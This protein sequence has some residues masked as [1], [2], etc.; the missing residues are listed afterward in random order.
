MKK[1]IISG[2]SGFIGANL[3]RRLLKDGHCVHLIL[4]DEHKTWRLEEIMADIQC[5]RVDIKNQ[6]DVEEAVSSIKPDWIFHL[7]AYGA[8]S[9][10]NDFQE[11]LNTNII[12]T[13][14]LIESAIKSGFES[15]INVGSSSEYGFKD[16]A[17]SERE[18][19]DPNSHYALTKAYATMYCRYMAMNHQL[20]I[21]TLRPYSV[22]GPYEEP[23]RF[24]PHLIVKGLECKL[25]PLV[26]PDVARDYIYVDDFI[27][28]CLLAAEKKDQEFGSFYNVGTGHQTTIKEAVEMSKEIL[29]VSEDPQWGS[30]D[31][32]NWDTNV[33]ISN[34]SLIQ[35]KLGW[36][37]KFNFR[38]GFQKTVE[39]F[40]SSPKMLEKFRETINSRK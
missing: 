32:R 18:W 25:P 34:S 10:Q 30:M 14:H 8:Y 1:V 37:P 3:A 22:Y 40:K 11:I 27:D 15:F 31:N 38:Q 5:H 13:I 36:Q 12:G 9:T 39:W 2:A 24:I 35:N 4:R 33:W 6:S 28:A 16:H 29:K 21:V 7:A 19:V 23:I 26:A 20:N 17:P